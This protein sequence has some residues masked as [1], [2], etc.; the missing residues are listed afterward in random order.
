MRGILINR[1]SILQATVLLALLFAG[2]FIG[3][4]IA[5]IGALTQISPWTA[6]IN[7]ILEFMTTSPQIIRQTQFMGTLFGILFPALCAA[8]MFSGNYKN[9][10]VLETATTGRT[11]LW[12]FLSMIVILPAINFIA[13]LN[14]QIPLPQTLIDME[15]RSARLLE[16][17][18][19]SNLIGTYFMNILIIAVLAAFSEEI[20]FRGVFLRVLI[21]KKSHIYI[22]VWVTAIIF[23]MMHAQF[24]GFFPR[25]LLGAY[26]G[27]L[28][29]RTKTMWV[30]IFAHFV[31]NFIQVTAIWIFRTDGKM[32]ES[33]EII[34]TGTT[35]WLTPLSII[36]FFYCYRRIIIENKPKSY[37]GR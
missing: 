18:L 9:Y 3:T 14:S 16:T 19:D 15:E 8:Y 21:R 26:F 2:Q 30:P 29:C 1:S 11:I 33:F 10:L 5:V 36:L 32:L 12:T 31:H 23:S 17:M 6:D 25:M 24:S 35:I 28:L 13:W 7:K 22:M 27:Y 37:N 4:F 34:G 20:L